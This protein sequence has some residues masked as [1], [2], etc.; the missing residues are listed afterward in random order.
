MEDYARLREAFVQNGDFGVT[1][2]ELIVVRETLEKAIT[3]SPAC[4]D[5]LALDLVM[6]VG[7]MQTAV[8]F[9]ILSFEIDDAELRASLGEIGS[10]YAQRSDAQFQAASETIAG[11]GID[12]LA[13]ADCSLEDA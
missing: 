9:L 12:P 1:G 8:L 7:N 3:D 10:H 6:S 11:W 4:L 13:R 2:G 5:G